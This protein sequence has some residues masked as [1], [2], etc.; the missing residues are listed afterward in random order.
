MAL[1][2][3]GIV[4]H[5][6][7]TSPNVATGTSNQPI[8]QDQAGSVIASEF[9]PRYA[10]LVLQG[11]VFAT[12]FAAAA[13]AAPSATATG[14]FFLFNPANSGKNLI[15]LDSQVALTTW[16]LVT[17]TSVAIGII[18]VANQTPTTTGAGAAISNTLVGSGNASVAK[19]YASGTLVGA[20]VLAMRVIADFLLATAVGASVLAI[21]DEIAGAIIIPPGSGIEIQGVS[22]TE[23]D[24]T[25]IVGLTWAELPV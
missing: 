1:P 19:T 20:P 15:L 18:P 22:G 13:L 5:G 11:D 2:I 3:S 6:Q 24:V 17:T 8:S 7:N 9:F 12:N 16:T 10:Q 4:L 21:K 25:A 14:A 23:A